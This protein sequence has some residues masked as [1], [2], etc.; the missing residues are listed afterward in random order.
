MAR[1]V[2]ATEGCGEKWPTNSTP[3]RPI[4]TYPPRSILH[5]EPTH[6]HTH[7]HTHT[8]THTH[9]NTHFGLQ[10]GVEWVL[11][12]VL[13][14]LLGVECVLEKVLGLQ[15]GV[16]CVVEECI[17]ILAVWVSHVFSA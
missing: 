12:K 9:T 15:L 5:S 8:H 11:E 2:G 4:R 6:T 13:G 17:R 14:L 16:E 7:K 1:T 3:H 10:L